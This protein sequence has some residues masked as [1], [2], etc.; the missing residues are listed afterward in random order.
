MIIIIVVQDLRYPHKEEGNLIG[1]LQWRSIQ[2][3][4]QLTQT[5]PAGFGRWP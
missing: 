3:C 4:Q 1:N 5:P 2:T